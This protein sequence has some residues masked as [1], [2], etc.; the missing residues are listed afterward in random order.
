MIKKMCLVGACLIGLSVHAQNAPRCEGGIETTGIQNGHTYCISQITMN[1][2]SAHSW[3]RAQGRHLATMA[4]AC[5]GDIG[6]CC[7]INDP[8]LPDYF[9]YEWTATANG[10]SAAKTVH[11]RGCNISTRRRQN[12]SRAICF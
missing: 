6:N 10:A 1:W 5:N 2:W 11:V 7:N 9:E 4:E 3:C 12:P 8:A